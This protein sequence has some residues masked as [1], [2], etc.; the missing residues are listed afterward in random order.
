MRFDNIN[1]CTQDTICRVNDMLSQWQP[2][3][4]VSS[5][6]TE[7]MDMDSRAHNQLAA[8]V[9]ELLRVCYITLD[10]LLTG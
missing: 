1:C 4:V 9:T 3:T 8:I 6:V 10:H 5:L 2:A 7:C